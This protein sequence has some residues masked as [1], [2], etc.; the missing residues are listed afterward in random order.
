MSALLHFG[1]VNPQTDWANAGAISTS[2]LATEQISLPA[3]SLQTAVEF[4]DPVQCELSRS[5]VAEIT[6]GSSQ[7]T[8]PFAGVSDTSV[9]LATYHL[10]AGVPVDA[11]L[12]S[13]VAVESGAGNFIIKGNAAATASVKV[14]W[15]VAKF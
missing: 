14:A 1:N 15:L 8:V 7:I 12:T 6:P 2:S 3:G 10:D 9:I 5:G 4:N 11:T 13:I